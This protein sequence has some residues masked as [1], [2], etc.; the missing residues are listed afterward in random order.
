M[1]FSFSR[2]IIYE[3]DYVTSEKA[4][5]LVSEDFLQTTKCGTASCVGKIDS[6]E[7]WLGFKKGIP[8]WECSCT[9][10]MCSQSSKPCVHAIALAIAWDRNRNVPD[11]T[12]EDI[13]FLTSMK[14]HQNQRL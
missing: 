11:P 10:I 7:I 12:S 6:F 1:A 3:S 4:S 2:L 13:K 5:K 8:S 14:S 9:K